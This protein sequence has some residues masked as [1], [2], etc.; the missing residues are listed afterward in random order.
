MTLEERIRFIEYNTK[1]YIDS[2]IE[3]KPSESES[4]VDPIRSIAYLDTSKDIFNVLPYLGEIFPSVVWKDKF[5]IT[6]K[7]D[8]MPFIVNEM[9]MI[10]RYSDT[11]FTRLISAQLEINLM[12][13]KEDEIRGL[14]TVRRLDR[15][16][17]NYDNII[18]LDVLQVESFIKYESF[19][20]IWKF[21]NEPHKP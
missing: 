21:E 1:N 10:Y 13:I 19:L 4:V 20:Y 16:N 6:N 18:K 5:H 7:A 14:D 15:R 3:E 11:F 2:I 17:T 8:F 9:K 12:K